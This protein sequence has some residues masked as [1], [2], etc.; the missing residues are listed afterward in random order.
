[1]KMNFSFRQMESSE[2]VKNYLVQK[3]EHKLATYA[4]KF[5]EANF[6]LSVNRHLQLVQCTIAAGDGFSLQVEAESQDMYASIDMMV[7]KLDKQLKRKKEVL[8]NHKRKENPQP[9][10]VKVDEAD[11]W[12]NISVDA[13]DILKFEAIRKKRYA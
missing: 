6:T 11:E 1:M 12:Q 13:E 5:I 10:V 3:M 2:A 7:D 9:R 4:T 8:K